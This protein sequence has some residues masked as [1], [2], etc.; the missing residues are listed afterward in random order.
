MIVI[1][2]NY[3]VNSE[4]LA[5]GEYYVFSKPEKGRIRLGYIYNSWCGSPYGTY[6]SFSEIER[7]KPLSLV[8]IGTSKC[9]RGQLKTLKIDSRNIELVDDIYNRSM[10]WL[11]KMQ[12]ELKYPQ[13]D[14]SAGCTPMVIVV[15]KGLLSACYEKDDY[16]QML[17]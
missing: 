3:R 9:D 4:I 11:K 6:M 16:L 15:N 10:S 1:Q 13:L 7:G 14:E 8:K 17:S 5:D 12:R 2:S